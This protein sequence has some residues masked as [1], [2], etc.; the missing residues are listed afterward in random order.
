MFKDVLHLRLFGLPAFLLPRLGD[1]PFD[2]LHSS[3]LAPRGPD[4]LIFGAAA[5]STSMAVKWRMREKEKKE[6]L[7]VKTAI[8]RCY[9]LVD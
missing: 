3:L 8:K 2:F 5:S 9:D 7:S 4:V 6:Y 1:Q